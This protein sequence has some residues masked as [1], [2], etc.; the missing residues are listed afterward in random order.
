MPVVTIAQLK[1]RAAEVKASLWTTNAEG[2]MYA[3]SAAGA[4]QSTVSILGLIYGNPSTQLSLFLDRLKSGVASRDSQEYFYNQRVA[5][6]IERV[7]DQALA[8][9][10]SGL[11]GSVRVQAKGEVL[12]DFL[13]L[14]REALSSGDAA[15][16]R[17]AAVLSAAALEETLKQIG[18]VAG[19]DVGSRD[20]RGVIQKLKD[21]GLLVGAQV[22]LAGG[23]VKFR[24][25]AFHGQFDLIERPTID[26]ALSFVEGLLMAR[27]A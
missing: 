12:G 2:N 16:E 21:A 8:D 18:E 7:L 10:E 14:A 6:E 25:H 26:S 23:L 20:M 19:L 22:G 24:D 5:A 13:G 3:K 11:T 9:F 15:A 4:S 1:A 27:F 17:V